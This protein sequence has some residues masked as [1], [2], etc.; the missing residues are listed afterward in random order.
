MKNRVILG[1]VIFLA[2]SLVFWKI[3]SVKSEPTDQATLGWDYA[4]NTDTWRVD[5]SGNFIPGTDDNVSIGSS[6]KQVKNLY[7]DGTAYLD[8]LQLDGASP[9]EFEGDTADAYE[10]TISVT[11]PTADRTITLPNATGTVLL[12]TDIGNQVLSGASP[13][14]FEGD[15]A[16][17]YETTVA[18]TDPTADRT[19]TIPDADVNLGAIS[20]S[21][22][23]SP[24]SYFTIAL[25]HDGQETAT[26]DPVFTFQMPFAA[27]LVE[28][29][30]CARDIDTADGDETYTIDVE[31]AGTSVLSSAVSI[32]ADNTPVVGT[33]SDDAIADDAKVEVVLTLGGT[34]PA[35]DDLTVLLTFKVAHTN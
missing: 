5:S 12:N 8:G 2:L 26:V 19:V 7:I 22:L 29:S 31:E 30:A 9:I 33:V 25:T 11:D 35:I 17:D 1:L 24:N 23:A 20:N 34:T 21:L 4:N 15:T 14:V 27:T 6:S 18:V 13:L 10:T 16:D 3:T 32:T 28:V